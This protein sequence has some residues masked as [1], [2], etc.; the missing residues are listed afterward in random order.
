[1]IVLTRICANTKNN[2][3]CQKLMTYRDKY[4]LKIAENNNSECRSCTFYQRPVWNK[5]MDMIEFYGEKKKKEIYANMIKT[6]SWFHHTEETKSTMNAHLKG[7]TYEEIYGDREVKCGFKKGEDNVAHRP[8][9]KEKARQRGLS[10]NNPV[11]RADVKAKIRLKRIA[12]LEDAV[13]HGGQ[14]KPAYNHRAC[15]AF[16]EMMK[17]QNIFIQHAENEGE[18]FI[19]ELG[20]WVDGYDKENNIVY[21][22]DEKNH[23]NKSTG[24]LR[25]KDVLRQIEIENFLHCIMIRIK[26]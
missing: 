24:E 7:K 13:F 14:M 16:N 22:W 11:K 3:N 1:M 4:I 20:F 25:N 26:E 19:K 10:E 2:P 6:R 9:V 8:D 18:F 23:F 21:E 17:E 12:R 15:E 5:G